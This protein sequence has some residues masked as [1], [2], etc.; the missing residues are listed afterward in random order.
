MA[1]NDYTLEDSN[2]VGVTEY[3]NNDSDDDDDSL[4]NLMHSTA[5]QNVRSDGSK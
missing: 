3:A 4:V 5:E 1:D 2:R